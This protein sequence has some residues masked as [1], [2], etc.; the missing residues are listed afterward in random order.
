MTS[1]AFTHL[2][3]LVLAAAALLAFAGLAAEMLEGETLGFDRAVL[4]ALR[5]PAAPYDPIGPRWMTE[6]ARDVTGLGGNAILLFVTLAVAGYLALV[7]KRAAALLV[8]VTVGGGVALSTLLKHAFQRPRPD[9]VPHGV[10]VYSASFPSGHAMLSA[11]TYLTLAALLIQVQ[12]QWRAKTYVL[13][14][15]VLVTLLIGISRVYLG[16]HWPT[17]VLA[18]WCIG[19]AW[20]LL[21]WLAALALQRNRRVERSDA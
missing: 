5:H 11:V 4:L 6:V 15:A 1:R 20:A 7:R 2:I 9:L 14:L 10:E 13:M 18:G 19:A 21:C 17:D 16:V 8:L 3:G 12:V